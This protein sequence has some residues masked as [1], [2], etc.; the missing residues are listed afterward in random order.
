MKPCPSIAIALGVV[1]LFA[2]SGQGRGIPGSVVFYS[3]RTGN[4]EIFLMNPD[5]T[6]PTRITVNPASDVD[7]DISTNGREIVFSSNRTGNNDIFVTDR[8]GISVTNLEA[9]DE[10]AR[11]NACGV[12]RSG[13]LQ[14][15][16]RRTVGGSIAPTTQASCGPEKEA[17][18]VGPTASKYGL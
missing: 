18:G 9:A 11:Q 5:G 17:V 1:G 6:D 7:P 13:R 8:D 2:S 4:N 16:T 15:R 3:A 14:S 10:V 12:R